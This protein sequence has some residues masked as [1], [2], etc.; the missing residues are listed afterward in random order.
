LAEYDHDE[1]ADIFKT[2]K[3]EILDEINREAE[4]FL[5]AQL[6]AALAADQRAL[7][8]ASIVGAVLAILIGGLATVASSD[9]QLSKFLFCIVPMAICFI[10]SLVY[11]LSACRPIGFASAG[12]NPRQW[13]EDIQSSQSLHDSKAEMAAFYGTAIEENRNA[14]EDAGK[15]L[16][17][18]MR[19]GATGLI[20]GVVALLFVIS[21]PYVATS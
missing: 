1:Y 18:A 14:M 8:Y 2:A 13:I 20:I 19:W 21:A 17:T 7:V 4:L 9:M 3:P 6:A 5:Q 10:M 15:R 12:N 16:E 11:A